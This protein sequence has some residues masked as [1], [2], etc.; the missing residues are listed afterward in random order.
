MKS[1][2]RIEGMKRFE[3]KNKENAFCFHE[4]SRDRLIWF[5]DFGAIGVLLKGKQTESVCNQ[6]DDYVDY[7][8]INNAFCGN[9]TFTPKRVTII[10][11]K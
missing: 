10:Q 7:Q 8:N 2:G 6:R 4:K 11:M 1:N 5:C 9:N 3:I